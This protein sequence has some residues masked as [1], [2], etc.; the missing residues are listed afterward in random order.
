MNINPNTQEAYQLMHDGALAMSNAEQAGFHIDMEYVERK[1]AFL[2]KKM[3][4]TEDQFKATD[5]FKHWQHTS[6]NKVNIHSPQQLSNFL[7][8]IK[9]IDVGNLTASGQGSTNEETLKQLNIPE[10]NLL[11]ETTRFKKPWDVLNGFANE[12]IDGVVHPFYNLHLVRSFRSSSDSPNFQNIPK[13]DEEVMQL[14]RRAIFPRPGHQFLEIDYSGIEVRINACINKDPKLVKY[15]SDPKSDMHRDVAIQL[16]LLDKLDKSL[17]EHS[18]LRYI[19]KNG[20]VFPEFYGSYWKNVADQIAC[21]HGKLGYGK[22]LPNQGIAMPEG[23]LSDHFLSK[24]I[25]T[26]TMFEEH[27]KKI[28]ADFWGKRFKVYSEWKNQNWDDYKKNGYVDL[29]TG[30]RCSGVM[31]KKQVNNYPGQG[32]AFHCLLWSFI[33]LDK[34]RISQGWDAKLVGQIHDSIIV[35]VAP[36]ELEHVAKVARRITTQALPQAWEWINVPLDVEMELCPVDGS[37]ADKT[38][39]IN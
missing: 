18:N 17:P 26:L 19:A 13:R 20:F 5:F 3:Q 8:K 7:Y 32:S 36:R 16:F 10:L 37:W 23:T 22:W 14:C 15:V 33:Q 9:K 35:D 24:G 4:R 12:Q 1:K 39:Y 2:V 34:T 21:N 30:F 28:E 27:V 25:K 29:P 31:D 6:K 11:L 38:K